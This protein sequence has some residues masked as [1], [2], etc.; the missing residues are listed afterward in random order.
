MNLFDNVFYI[1]DPVYEAR[2]RLLEENCKKFK[3]LAFHKKQLYWR[4]RNTF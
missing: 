2:N 4:L 3:S 1:I